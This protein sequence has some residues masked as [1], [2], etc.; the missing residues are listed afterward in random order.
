MRDENFFNSELDCYFEDKSNYIKAY[1]AIL[2]YNEE[3]N[4]LN[5]FRIDK[6]KNE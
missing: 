2:N 3:Q 6:Y 4:K 5:L 1:D